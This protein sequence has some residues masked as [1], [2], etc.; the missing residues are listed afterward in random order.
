[1]AVNKIRKHF[2]HIFKHVGPMIEQHK[3]DLLEKPVRADDGHKEPGTLL[4]MLV[5]SAYEHGDPLEWRTELVAKRYTIVMFASMHTTAITLT[6]LLLD[7]LSAPPDYRTLE[8]LREEIMRVLDDNGGRWSKRVL[9]QLV[10]MDSAIRES[11][12]LHSLSSWSLPRIVVSKGGIDLPDGLH[13]PKGSHICV[14]SYSVQRDEQNYKDPITFDPF[15]FSR[16]FPH[17][18]KAKQPND[19]SGDL[20]ENVGQQKHV[21]AVST[22]NVFFAFGHGQHACPCRFFAIQSIKLILSH[23]LLT[24]DFRP[25]S[26]RPQNHWFGDMTVPD[27]NALISVRRR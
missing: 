24:Y 14:P 4:Q 2:D 17:G 19:R 22:N 15:R 12:R 27:P 20:D 26:P 10:N 13:L 25:I 3:R 11:M 1:M 6:H 18:D 21:P 23:L 7:I 8:V 9:S 5:Q 16:N